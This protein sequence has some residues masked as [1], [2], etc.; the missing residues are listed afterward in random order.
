M[1]LTRRQTV[2]VLAGIS[3][4]GLS[5]CMDDISGSNSSGNPEYD[6]VEDRPVYISENINLQFP[7]EINRASVMSDADMIVLS[8]DTPA[9]AEQIVNWIKNQKAVSV[10]GDG[11]KVR[12]TWAT[13]RESEPYREFESEGR[14]GST[15][16][17]AK[18]LRARW[19]N[20]SIAARYTASLNR[21]PNSGR[22]IEVIE[23]AFRSMDE[24]GSLP[25]DAADESE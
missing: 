14:G 18:M 2:T 17:P 8:P 10:I 12:E 5:G 16:V 25:S 19:K 7:S 13:W 23:R 11:N 3:A 4:C 15:Q 20:G 22:L 24:D 21:D 9:N 1:D 6:Y